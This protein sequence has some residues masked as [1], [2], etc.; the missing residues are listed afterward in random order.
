MLTAY[1]LYCE[2]VLAVS[3]P[4]LDDPRL[5]IQIKHTKKKLYSQHADTSVF[6]LWQNKGMHMLV[7]SLKEADKSENRWP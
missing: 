4:F 2:T 3:N 5:T 1:S 7:G 6:V